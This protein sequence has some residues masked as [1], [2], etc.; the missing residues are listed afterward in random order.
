MPTRAQLESAL[1]NADAAGDTAAAK[2]LANALKGGQYSVV[3]APSAAPAA[4]PEQQVGAEE[5]GLIERAIRLPETAARALVEDGG[6]ARGAG[7]GARST[8]EGLAS[9]PVAVADL[10]RA[11]MNE[12]GSIYHRI[13]GQEDFDYLPRSYQETLSSG[14][15]DAGL[16]TP[17]TGAEQLLDAATRGVAAA[18]TGIGVG[19]V[20]AG[21]A[22][23]TAA[24]IGG[25]LR[26]SPG[27]QAA[28]GGS[29]GVSSELARQADVGPEGQQIAGLVG[30]LAGG[31]AA[32]RIDPRAPQASLPAGSATT[33]PQAAGLREAAAQAETTA[34]QGA[35]RIGLDWSGLDDAL[36]ERLA[37]NAQ[38]ALATNSDLPP[39]AVARASIYESLGI[40][41]TRALITRTFEDALN[42]Q[43]LLTEAEGQA[44]RNVYVQNNQAIRQQIRDLVPGGAQAVDAPT[45]GQQ[46]RQSVERGERTAQQLSNRAHNLAEAAEGGNQTTIQPV[47]NYLQENGPMLGSME[48][49]RP[50]VAYLRQIGAIADDNMESTPG[51]KG[52]RA[53]PITLKELGRMREIVNR[54]WRSAVNSGDEAAAAPL[55]DLRSIINAAE[56]GAGG[57]LYK[58]YRTLRTAKGGAYENNP[59]IDKLISDQRGYRGTDLIEDSQ[60]FDKAILGS[61]P[62]QF[63]RTWPR[64]SME[65]R[66]LTRNQVARYIEDRAFS[67]MGTNEAGDVVASAAKVNQALQQIGPQ[68]LETIF[69]PERAARLDR[70]NKAVREISNPPRG[71]VPQGAA[72]KLSYLYR[73]TLNILGLVGRIPGINVVID[74]AERRASSAAN[75]AAVQR[76]IV[77]MAPRSAQAQAQNY[78][79]AIPPSLAAILAEQGGR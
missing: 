15:T 28:A 41:P 45:F 74:V 53:M 13:T 1:R 14:L 44:L 49:T 26:S 38:Q 31:V 32:G 78:L 79:D 23:P 5:P 59:L 70:L 19:R 62:E 25:V 47:V 35:Q 18:P 30:G 66:A 46:F 58:A 36:K 75:N 6:A 73:N 7:L 57:E 51:G 29:A 24:Q 60:V 27:A 56:E 48:K 22:S 20:L 76:A 3:A 77:P 50:V 37:R 2:Q 69:G 34:Q 55:N 16:P 65:A 67:N 39:E 72:P 40:R 8:V 9:L 12:L 63:G 71:T 54:S 64:L 11:G 61:S 21:S 10:A 4:E 33:A 17:E 43:N 52:Y 42:E 68:K